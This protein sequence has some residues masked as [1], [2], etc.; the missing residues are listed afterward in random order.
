MERPAFESALDVLGQNRL[1]AYGARV[2]LGAGPLLFA[3]FLAGV[4]PPG[5]MG[6]H[7]TMAGLAAWLASVRWNLRP[8]RERTT[9][10]VDREGVWSEA[11]LRVPRA[12]IRDG[13]FQPRANRDRSKAS[14]YGSSVRLLGKHGGIVFEAEAE[15]RDALALLRALGLDPAS[16]R[17]EFNGS[18][19]LYATLRRNLLFV[20]GVVAGSFFL[21]FL[22]AS[23]GLSGGSFPMLVL[24]LILG[25][26]VPSKIAV[27][28][29]GILVRWL[30]QKTFIP[31]SEIVDVDRVDDRVIRLRLVGGR[32]VRLYTSMRRR[33]DATSRIAAE[34]RDAVLARIGEAREAFRA[35]GPAAD[36]SALVGRG[37]RTRADWLA[38]LGR[39]RDVEGGYRDA[40]VRE[41]DLW[42]VVEDPSAPE[43]AR[44]GAALLLRDSLDDAGKARVRV[45][46]EATAS[47]KLRVALD[48]AAG[49]AQEEALRTALSDLADDDGEAARRASR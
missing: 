5:V 13:F 48:A 44:G 49:D 42:R 40:V 17:A 41:D 25:A 11:Q 46:A 32:D 28:L 47:P 35:R 7:L 23:I 22:L 19:P 29:D 38:A 20:F 18:S 24:P 15:E 21:S 33:S 27:G 37:T 30:W 39:L 43:D 16:K 12:A 9:V 1:L 3:A 2:M 31:M 8:K 10:R 45:A 4:F 14:S 36:V 26:M 34:H 6:L